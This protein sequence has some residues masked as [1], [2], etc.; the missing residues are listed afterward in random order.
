MKK[1]LLLYV[2]PL[3]ALMILAALIPQAPLQ[4]GVTPSSIT[5]LRSPTPVMNGPIAGGRLLE[6]GETFV[7]PPTLG[8]GLQRPVGSFV[9]NGAQ[10]YIK[11]GSGPT[12][13]ELLQQGAIGGNGTFTAQLN[14]RASSVTGL[15]SSSLMCFHEDVIANP[16]GLYSTTLTGSGTSTLAIGN[17]V[18]GWLLNATG[19]TAASRSQVKTVGTVFGPP[20]TNR[21]YMAVRA[22]IPTAVDAQTLAEIGIFD[23]AANRTL[24]FCAA[25]S[26]STTIYQLSYDSTGTCGAGGGTFASSGVA[27]STATRIWE[28]WSVGDGKIHF[29][30]DFT[31]VG[32]SPVTPASMPTNSVR[33]L[34]DVLNQTTASNRE[35]DVDYMHLCWS[36][37]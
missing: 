12:A 8:S 30:I 10:A 28:M 18:G 26:T 31:E 23:V 17:V 24:G 33:P 20:G 7:V 22:A 29:A 21:F 13:W 6:I 25:G 11:T 1:A 4:A 34:V 14:Q 27:I 19:A 36:Q 3:V 35:I 2:A 9:Y 15:S 37:T 32:T 5:S 16:S